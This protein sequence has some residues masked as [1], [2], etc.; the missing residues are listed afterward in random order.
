MSLSPRITSLIKFLLFLGIGV[1]IT[2]LSLKDLTDEHR[3]QLMRSFREADYVWVALVIVIGIISHILRALRWNMLL[4][5]V[6]GA[7]PLKHTFLAVM[8]GYFANMAFPRLGEVTRCGVLATTDKIPVNKSFGT[9]ITERGLDLLIFVLLFLALISTQY[10]LLIDYLDEKIFP[11]LKEKVY[12]A[13]SSYIFY[14]VLLVGVLAFLGLILMIRNARPEH[15][16]RHKVKHT[17]TGFWKGLISIRYIRMPWLF[18]AYSLLIWGCYFL[19]TYLCFRAL[20][21]T[22]HLGP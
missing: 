17:V 18:V 8:I 1:L 5:P 6:G 10:R 12:S 9:V 13:G 2:W 22:T 15:K 19:M 3:S 16:F 14:L 4:E 20:P 7:P 11:G 21:E